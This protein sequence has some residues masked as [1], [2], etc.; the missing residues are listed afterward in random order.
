MHVAIV[1]KHH[2]C[3]HLLMSHPSLDLTIRDKT[4]SSPFATAMA[5]RD[6][7]AANTILSREPNAAHQVVKHHYIYFLLDFM[8]DFLLE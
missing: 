6:N 8:F 7:D 3:M 5:I 2:M 1:N 4:G